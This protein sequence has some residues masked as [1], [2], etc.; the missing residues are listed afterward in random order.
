MYLEKDK[1][2]KIYNS[3]EINQIA[4]EFY[5]T[6]YDSDRNSNMGSWDPLYQPQETKSE[7][8]FSE[9]K[10]IVDALKK[11]KAPSSDKITNEYVK[12]GGWVGS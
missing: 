6:L 5:K 1:G 7:F 12:L 3:N 10:I 8:L 4:T 11:N 9:V 2:E